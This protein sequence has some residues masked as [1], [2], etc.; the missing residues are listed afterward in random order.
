MLFHEYALTPQIFAK[1]YC[2]DRLFQKDLVNFLKGLRKNSMIGNLNKEQWQK[3]VKKELSLLPLSLR[4]KL[5]QLL[6]EL[7]KY[8]RIVTH[9]SVTKE[10]SIKDEEQWLDLIKNEDNIEPYSAIV[11]T[12]NTDKLHTNHLTIEQLLEHPSWENRRYSFILNQTKEN[13]EKHTK[14]FLMYAKKLTISD[15]YFTYN[16][17]DDETLLLFADLF[18]QR[19]GKRLQNR[20]IIIHTSYNEKDKFVDINSLKYKIQW[21]RLFQK[22]YENYG[23]KV[24]LNV[25]KDENYPKLVHDRYLITDQGGIHSGRGFTI[26]DAESTWSLLENDDMRK[27]LNKFVAN[28]AKSFSLVFSLNKDCEIDEIVDMQ[29]KVIKILHDNERGKNGFVRGESGES[30]YFV[31]PSSFYLCESIKEGSLVEFEAFETD[32]GKNAK[33]LKMVTI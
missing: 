31:M 6:Q 7:S 19:R 23:H 8:N 32:R 27:C 12:E 17:N 28:Y 2:E 26:I 25:W 4:D 9:E 1:E 15:P 20:Q 13:I 10:E 22:I 29:G 33:I 11:S 18:A 30:Y 16:R 24:T 21:V 5:M 3:E 14:K